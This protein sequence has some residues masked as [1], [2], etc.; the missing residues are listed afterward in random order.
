[1]NR[2]ARIAVL[3]VGIM[4]APMARNLARAG[5]AVAV[6]NR[7]PEKAAALRDVGVTVAASPREA[8]RGADAV[9][10]MLSTG[11]VCDAVLFDPADGVAPALGR[12]A[13]VCVMSSI[14]VEAARAQAARLSALGVRYADAPV[15]G[16]E[17]GAIDGALTIMMGAA[18]GDASVISGLLTPLGRV[19]HVGPVGAGQLAKLANQLIVGVTI[20]AVAEAVLLVEA[21]GGDVRATLA[22]L[23]GG[24]ADSAIL[25]QHGQRML[26]Q[27]FTPGAQASVQ[28]KDL[29]TVLAQA[30]AHGQSPP[31]AALAREAFAALCAEGRDGLDHSALYLHLRDRAAKP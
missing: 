2:A 16:G 22:A 13:C 20:G 30:L 10:L 18:P 15:S 27:N 21:G 19:T 11:A 14:P 6:W 9:I 23:Q 26:E 5:H 24:F 28:L 25:R 3:G 8:V 7:S 1:V 12:G 29:A 17:R 4:G 31:F